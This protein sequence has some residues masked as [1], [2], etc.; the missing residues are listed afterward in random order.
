[1]RLADLLS[2][3]DR[4]ALR[5]R[6]PVSHPFPNV[7]SHPLPK[8]LYDP[9]TRHISVSFA[10]DPTYPSSGDREAA[11]SNWKDKTYLLTSIPLRK[12]RSIIDDASAL[13]TSAIS[14]PFSLFGH[15][16]PSTPRPDQ[17]FDSGDID[18]REEEIL[19]QD[20]S[21]EGEVDD[22]AEKWRQ[23]RVI[24]I[25]KEDEQIVGEKAKTRRQWIV[26]PL[27]AHKS[28]TGTS[29]EGSR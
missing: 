18:L 1:M 23:V 15:A 9:A 5:H 21:E 20:R 2:E 10:F 19:E 17:V 3:G 16:A 25:S 11:M 26:V 12:P 22:S 7:Y 4:L 8:F 24:G 13:L 28:R 29:F 6:R 27:R 14:M